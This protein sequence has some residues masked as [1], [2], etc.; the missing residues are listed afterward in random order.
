MQDLGRSRSFGNIVYVFPHVPK[1]AGTTVVHHLRKLLPAGHL[2]EARK[3][4]P[5]QAGF[6]GRGPGVYGIHGHHVAKRA[7]A[8]ALA[9]NVVREIILIR[10]PVGYFTS[11]YCFYKVHSRKRDRAARLTFE[12]WYRCQI[13]NPMRHYLLTRYFGV[14]GLR[15]QMMSERACLD[16]LSALL[17]GCWFVGSYRHCGSLLAHITRELGSTADIVSVNTRTIPFQLPAGFD[18]RILAD[19]AFD[20]SL[21][22]HWADRAWHART[23][24]PNTLSP[25]PRPQ[26][27]SLAATAWARAMRHIGA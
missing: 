7:V 17:D 2:V 12:D 13:K 15:E 25:W 22:E 18:A 26:V 14:S 9:G 6:G 5:I 10:D 16:H 11:M 8:H 4:Q 24:R 27:A 19:N 20:Q 3:G 23:E 21:Y 1:C